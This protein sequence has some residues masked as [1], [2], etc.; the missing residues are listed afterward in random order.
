MKKITVIL[1]SLCL[2]ALTTG[3]FAGGKSETAEKTGESSKMTT[4]NVA[5]PA[6]PDVLEPGSFH[7]LTIATY[8]VSYNIFNNL[9]EYDFKGDKGLKPALAES[10]NL[11]D[12]KTLEIKLRKGVKFHNGDELTSDDVLFTFSDERIFGDNPAVGSKKAA[13]YWALFDRVEAVDRYT[14]KFYTKDADPVMVNRLTQPVFQII[15]K[16][17]YKEAK[18]FEEWSFKPVGTGPFKVKDLFPAD[19]LILEAHADYWGG[20]PE[21]ETLIFKSV[22]EDSARIA[23][24]MAGDYQVIGG[25]S[26][27]LIKTIEADKNL[28]IEGGPSASY[29]AVYFNLHKPY[30]DVKLRKAMSLAID[31]EL[32]VKT[33]FSG[34]TR[35]TNG[36]QEPG[37]DKM[38]VKDH[39]Y[40]KYDL[41]KA[42]QL[43]K[44]SVYKGESIP[45]YIQNDYY[46]NEVNVA[47]AM[48]EMWRTAGINVQLEVKENWA[49]VNLEDSNKIRILGM[50]NT[51]HTDNFGDPSGCLWRT[52]NP[53]YDA[54]VFHNW[55]GA[56]VDEFNK[57]GKVL[58]SSADQ[59]E[60]YN[61]FKKMLDIFDNNPP[62][63]ILYQNVAFSAKRANINWSAYR[64][65]YMYFGPENFT[66]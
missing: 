36:L 40:P 27:D 65:V 66:Q 50:R 42:Q 10:W 17:A 54:Q 15:N 56:D 53:K 5:V 24:L 26:T 31:R 41:K 20:K 7:A 3:L 11:I 2:L 1:L 19:Q 33:L 8:R 52:Y 22:P 32:L 45:Y 37:Y 16:R 18:N 44:E 6:L 39:P 30:F 47:Q 12:A 4:L 28:T 14:V 29:L 13:G 25:V 38:F 51:S 55:K 43:V 57:L 35:V 9:I 46:P 63:L 23:G 48:V 64:Q 59:K 21:V 61:A 58:D 49:Q 34:R 62:A 60:R